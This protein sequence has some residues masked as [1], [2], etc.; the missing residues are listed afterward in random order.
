MF[1]PYEN[2]TNKKCFH[3][4]SNTDE[5]TFLSGALA[6]PFFGSRGLKTGR[7]VVSNSD[8]ISDV[9]CPNWP[10]LASWGFMKN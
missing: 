2:E 9:L 7:G 4:S 8:T 5:K 6:T 10:N 3:Q 1:Q